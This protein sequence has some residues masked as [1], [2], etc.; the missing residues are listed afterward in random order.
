MIPIPRGVGRTVDNQGQRD[1][2]ADPRNGF[3]AIVL[4]LKDGMEMAVYTGHEPS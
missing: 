2:M 1:Y 3:R 4:P